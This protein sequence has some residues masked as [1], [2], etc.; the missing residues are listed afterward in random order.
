MQSSFS[1]AFKTVY[2]RREEYWKTDIVETKKKLLKIVVQKKKNEGK[3]EIYLLVFNPQMKSWLMMNKLVQ[4]QVLQ[5]L[6]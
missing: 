4:F 3:K 2:H 1:F 6:A 5:E